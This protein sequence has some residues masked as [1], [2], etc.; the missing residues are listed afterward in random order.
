MQ[1][2]HT[3]FRAWDML[4]H[5][6]C[7]LYVPKPRKD[8]LYSTTLCG[9]SKCFHLQICF[10]C[11]IHR[12]CNVGHVGKAI[13]VVELMNEYRKDYP[14]DDFVCSSVI[15]SFCRIGK[16]ELSLR[17]ITKKLLMKMKKR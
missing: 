10:C 1:N 13:E 8:Y 4:I 3:P 11:V 12:F 16:P 17:L 9:K 14:F 2:P 7:C 15:S 6:L 5:G